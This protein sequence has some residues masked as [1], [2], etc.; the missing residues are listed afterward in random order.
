[1][2]RRLFN[3]APRLVREVSDGDT[4][5]SKVI[6]DHVAEI[7]RGL[8]QHHEGEDLLLWDRLESRSPACSIHVALMR[9]QHASVAE[10]LGRL[11]TTVPLWRRSAD[12]EDAANVAA[13]LEEV[14]TTLFVHLGQEE[15]LIL[16]AA[17]TSLSQ[18]EWDELG[19]H[20]MAGIPK[21]RL[22]INLGF[23][24][25][26]FSAEERSAWMKANVPGFARALY[27]IFGRRQYES[28]YRQ[29]YGILPS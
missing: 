2:F 16:P 12:P 19:K 4:E 26:A 11:D 9:S 14:R 6:G 17:S 28:H 27:G 8:H 7:V 20:G 3:D 24:L 29:V 18:R 25:E 10:L 13:L 5:R 22:M 1:M 15:K 23:I 21:N